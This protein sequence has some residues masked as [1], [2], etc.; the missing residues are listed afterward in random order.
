MFT[1]S[2]LTRYTSKT[3]PVVPVTCSTVQ[4]TCL[5]DGRCIEKSHQCD[6]T[7]DCTDSSDEKSCSKFLL[8]KLIKVLDA[9]NLLL[10]N[11]LGCF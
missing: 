2:V 4:F 10:L 1:F 8:Y 7:S 3:L 9:A 11:T 6:G 5:S